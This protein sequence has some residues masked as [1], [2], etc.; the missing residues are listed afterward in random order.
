[1]VVDDRS[2]LTV[3]SPVWGSTLK[4]FPA[5]GGTIF[6]S[7]VYT[8]SLNGALKTKLDEPDVKYSKENTTNQNK[9][10]QK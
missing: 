2:P 1:M 6:S 3:I 8:I 7:I 5:S 9:T 10:H 4:N